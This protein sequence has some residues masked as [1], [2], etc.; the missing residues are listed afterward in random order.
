MDGL[1]QNCELLSILLPPFFFTSLLF[2]PPAYLE[3]WDEMLISLSF[4]VR[5]EGGAE[6]QRTLEADERLPYFSGPGLMPEGA[7]DAR[8]RSHSTGSTDGKP[9]QSRKGVATTED[10]CTNMSGVP[11]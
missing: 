7:G 1:N 2:L 4:A 10:P 11:L 8:A 3:N 5:S 9:P 6:S